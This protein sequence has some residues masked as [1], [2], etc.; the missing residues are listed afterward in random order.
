M[1]KTAMAVA[2]ASMTAVAAQAGTVTSDGADLVLKTKGGLEAKTAD[3]KASFKIA[4]RIQLDYNSFDGVI[5]TVPGEDGSDLFFRRARL[6]LEGHYVDWGYYMSYNLTDSGSIDQLHTTYK[7]FGELAQVVFGQQKED[8]GLEDTG[9]SKW[10]TAV[11]RSLP[12]NAFDTGNNLGVKLRG[13]NDFLTYSLGVYKQDLDENNEINS[14]ATARFVVRPMYSEDSVVHL[15]VG[16]TTRDGKF[17]QLGSRLGV[18]GGDEGKNANRIRGRYTGGALADELQAWNGELA[19]SFGPIHAMAEYFDGEISG[20]AGAP[21]IEADG[22]SVQLGWIL[23][24]ETRTY[25]PDIAAFDKIKPS[26]PDGA[27]EVFARYDELDVSDNDNVAPVQLIGETGN[28]LTLG[29][30]WYAN[31]LVKVALNYVH[32]ETDEKIGGEDNG[33]AIVGRIQFAF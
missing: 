10:T 15:G 2:I 4:G 6:E 5:N 18:R 17:T 13:F 31:E 30:N 26:S 28:T 33:D 20:A 8:F 25:K 12:A 29:V 9:S 24:G 27:W 14:A 32:A 19:G 3:G 11:E 1:K 23:T 16:Y 21:D 7:G 22:Y